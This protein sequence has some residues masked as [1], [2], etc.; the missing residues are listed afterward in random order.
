MTA[1]GT[2]HHDL[3]PG[4]PDW[5]DAVVALPGSVE[6]IVFDVE[7]L[8]KGYPGESVVLANPVLLPPVTQSEAA[9]IVELASIAGWGFAGGS[10]PTPWMDARARRG[11]VHRSAGGPGI[12]TGLER[13]LPRLRDRGWHRFVLRDRSGFDTES[14]FARVRTALE[15]LDLVTAVNEELERHLDESILGVVSLR[16]TRGL[17]ALD[18]A[19]ERVAVEA[20][21]RRPGLRILVCGDASEKGA[22]AEPVF[23]VPLG[24]GSTQ[25]PPTIPSVLSGMIDGF[26]ES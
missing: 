24:A 20:Q 1:G 11:A 9:L 18:G 13:R 19:L 25:E 8:E 16:A 2:I 15:P 17:T 4:S 21:R 7:V 22:P 14:G 3:D 26:D 5:T 10:A 6:T 23:L 12:L